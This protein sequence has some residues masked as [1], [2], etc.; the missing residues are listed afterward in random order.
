MEIDI[1]EKL[2]GEISVGYTSEDFDDPLNPGLSSL[3]NPDGVIEDQE[4]TFNQFQPKISGTWDVT[5]NT[6]LFASWGVGFKAGG[7]NNSGSAAT[8]NIFNNTLISGGVP[9]V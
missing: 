2:T 3:V 9:T 6:T 8:V 1:S 7:F 4:E 5:D